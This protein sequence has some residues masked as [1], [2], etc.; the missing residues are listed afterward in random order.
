MATKKKTTKIGLPSP[1][2]TGIYSEAV[3]KDNPPPYADSGVRFE[4]YAKVKTVTGWRLLR[5]EEGHQWFV[6][7]GVFNTATNNFSGKTFFCKSASAMAGFGD[8]VYAYFKTLSGSNR[9][10]IEAFASGTTT[11]AQKELYFD[12]PIAFKD[13][14]F[15]SGNSNNPSDTSIHLQGYFEENAE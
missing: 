2:V 12:P 14:I 4:G 5:Q 11:Y 6:M 1:L 15:M 8:F 13:G 7:N 10:Y 9:I 3:L